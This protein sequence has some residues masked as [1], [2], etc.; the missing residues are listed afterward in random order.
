MTLRRFLP[1]GASLSGK[2]HFGLTLLASV[3]LTGCSGSSNDSGG[4]NVNNAPSANAGTD[5]TVAESVVVQLA[6]SGTDADG[7]S[8]TYSWT[9]TAGPTVTLNAPNSAATSFTAPDVAPGNGE[10]LTFRL[11]A[12]DTSN[13]TGTDTVS[14]TVQEPGSTVTISGTLSFEFPTPQTA[15]NGL[16]FSNIQ[17]R[18]IRRATV[19]LLDDTGTTIIDSMVS[20]DSGAY[21]VHDDGIDQRH[22]T[23]SRRIETIREPVLGRRGSQ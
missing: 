23:S 5:Q 15:C 12:T 20:D 2:S 1:S 11:T 7:D 18:P 17:V 9:Q 19:Q 16:N 3:V 4:G 8:L 21:L 14:I 6:G 22:A 10:V 13:A